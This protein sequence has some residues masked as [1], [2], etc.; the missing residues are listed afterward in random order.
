[1]AQKVNDNNP[2][3]E[4]CGRHTLFAWHKEAYK[5]DGRNCIHSVIRS[6]GRLIALVCQ[7]PLDSTEKEAEYNAYLIAAAP[8]QYTILKAVRNWMQKLPGDMREPGLLEAV[9]GA[10]EMAQGKTEY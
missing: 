9:D 6:D 1:M 2:L 4:I 8:I 10:I 3:Y 7:S 5:Y